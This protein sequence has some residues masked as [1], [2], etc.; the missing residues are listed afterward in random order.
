[1]CSALLAV[2]TF[3]ACSGGAERREREQQAV[4]AEMAEAETTATR[5]AAL[6]A[7]GLWSDAHLLDR[8]VRAG[9]AP[10]LVEDAPAGPAWMEM[11]QVV[12]LAGGGEVHAW[13][14]PDSTARRRVTE[15][16]DPATGAPPG[17]VT[18]FAAPM[19]FL[20]QNNL[21]ALVTGG[22]ETN[23]ERIV[24]ALQ[25]GLPVASGDPPPPP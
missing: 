7:T 21:A 24:L 25:A 19:R 14:Y 17:T 1:M 10:R 13:I 2:A 16:L 12:V 5:A 9:V 3:T 8:L 22:R 15:S 18:P 4:R 11:R 6:P 20:V 23:Q